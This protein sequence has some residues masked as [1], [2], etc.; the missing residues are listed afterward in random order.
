[1]SRN[2]T[3]TNSLKVS[4]RN[5]IEKL[6]LD[7]S[8]LRAIFRKYPMLP[9]A[10]VRDNSRDGLLNLLYDMYELSPTH[11][12]CINS[13]LDFIVGDGI[14][15]AKITD[16]YI[17]LNDTP[18]NDNLK[19]VFADL[20]RGKVNGN[21]YDL[22]NNVALDFM[23]TGN[24]YINLVLIET[25]G[26]R[27]FFIESIQQLHIRRLME[28]GNVLDEYVI[29]E[30]L[31]DDN[32]LMKYPP[33]FVAKYPNFTETERGLETIIQIKEGQ[34]VYGRPDW[35]CSLY[36]QYAEFSV[37]DS[38]IKAAANDFL[39]RVL[40][41]SEQGDPNAPKGLLDVDDY[42]SNFTNKSDNP[43]MAVFSERPHG[44]GKMEVVQI[45]PTGGEGFIRTIND[46]D[47]AKIIG[48]HRWSKKLL[49]HEVKAGIGGT[50]IEQELTIRKTMIFKKR[51]KI[52][53]GINTAIRE[54]TNWIGAAEL[55]DVGIWYY[56]NLLDAEKKE[57]TTEKDV[58]DI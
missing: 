44:T 43:L 38:R 53:N 5:P 51:N 7:P 49:G 54:C 21:F 45:K 6:I 35:L 16:E 15:F 2:T 10:G 9:Y 11:G 27:S 37:L 3:I 22:S 19:T 20:F 39:P 29:S 46:I 56:S 32:Y 58:N 17:G 23:K 26:V 1:M 50:D 30:Y 24:G 42:E 8:K 34:N 41:E 36:N 47:E 55:Q 48:S 40:I 52:A 28:F 14:M 12:S 33:R 25:L 18:I 13:I 31:A 57:D 4:D